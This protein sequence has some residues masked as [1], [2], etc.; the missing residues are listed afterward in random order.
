MHK[1]SDR[2][3]D[4]ENA[5]NNEPDVMMVPEKHQEVGNQ[6]AYAAATGALS[7]IRLKRKSDGTV[8]TVL[9]VM[10][11]DENGGGALYPVGRLFEGDEGVDIYEAPEG[12]EVRGPQNG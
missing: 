5:G 11:P 12:A 2:F 9:T 6:M 4:M 7:L 8:H 1:Q 10:I 3:K